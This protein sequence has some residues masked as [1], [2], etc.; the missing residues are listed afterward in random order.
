MCIRDRDE[1]IDPIEYV[2]SLNSELDRRLEE[3]QRREEEVKELQTLLHQQSETRDE[4]G[5]AIGAAA[6]AEMVDSDELI[7]EERAK[8]KQMQ[9]DWEERFRE[10]EITASLERAKLSRERRELA[11]RNAE[12]EEQLVHFR[13]ESD[14]S[15]KAGVSGSRRWLAKLGLSDN[16]E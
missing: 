11:Q 5:V 8:L 9:T 12:L 1:T 3:V 14:Q 16:K 7:R 10:G 15:R 13:R 6:I 4:S 2:T